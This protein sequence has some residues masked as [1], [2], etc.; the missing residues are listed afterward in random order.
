MSMRFQQPADGYR[1]GGEK[2]KTWRYILPLWVL[3]LLIGF[4]ITKIDVRDATPMDFGS[5]TEQNG[6]TEIA[7]PQVDSTGG[8]DTLQP[9]PDGETGGDENANAAYPMP[10]DQKRVAR[11]QDL[12][13][14]EEEMQ[15]LACVV[16]LEASTEEMRGQQ[17]VV[18]VILNRV[19][20][21]NFPNSVH[22]VIYEDF[23]T[24]T[25][26][27]ETA[28]YISQAEPSEEQYLAIEK[29]LYGPTIL[30]ED[31]VFFSKD[32]E[33]EYVWGT[34]GEHIFCYQYPWA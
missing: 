13:I 18:E 16:F 28:P 15:E 30:P 24:A 32:G 22:D 14:S 11:Y 19:L 3:V 12:E 29:A 1:P 21:S 34:I 2:I 5:R 6:P 33:N 10:P 9:E 7:P 31:V 26:Q 27:F 25:P 23:G 8:L 17:A 4:W 20:A